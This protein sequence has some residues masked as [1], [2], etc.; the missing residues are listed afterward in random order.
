MKDVT[1]DSKEAA[2]RLAAIGV[3]YITTNILE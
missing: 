2:E 3:D 1:V